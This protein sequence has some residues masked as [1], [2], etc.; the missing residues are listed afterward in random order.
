[1]RV[2]QYLVSRWGLSPVL[3]SLVVVLLHLAF[4]N[5]S[6]LGLL[7]EDVKHI[8]G[9]IGSLQDDYLQMGVVTVA[10]LVLHLLALSSMIPSGNLIPL[11]FL[12]ALLGRLFFPLAQL[13][14]SGHPAA[15]FAVVGAACLVCATT[16]S[17]V[18]ITVITFEYTQQIVVL[19]P[20]LIS[21]VAAYSVATITHTNLYHLLIQTK[22]LPLLPRLL[23]TEQCRLT[24]KDIMS[25]R[26]I[27]YM[28]KESSMSD[29]A[30]LM[31]KCVSPFPVIVV[32]HSLASLELSGTLQ[33][34]CLKDYLY[35]QFS[36]FKTSRSAAN[37]SFW[38]S[39]VDLSHPLLHLNTSP[40]TI[41]PHLPLIK[42]HFI[43]LMLGLHQSLVVDQ[44]RL[45][46]VVQISD[47]VK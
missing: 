22:N 45:A 26:H 38:N 3:Y 36:Q 10:R 25:T 29:L 24:A 21:L 41:S 19:F 17:I 28:T 2:R 7:G 43:Y 30:V 42:L 8:M 18:A 34:A 27:L 40:F 13:M 12:G 44:G 5:Y 20:L 47:F 11:F 6:T 16:H 39:P 15:A 1:M 9:D 33:L 35:H 31:G 4:Y 23:R 46:G 37:P 14:G 32:L